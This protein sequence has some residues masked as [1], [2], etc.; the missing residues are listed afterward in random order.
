MKPEV[1]AFFS[2]VIVALIGFIGQFIM[3]KSQRKDK[4]EDQKNT[5]NLEILQTLE[6]IKENL[7][8][9]WEEVKITRH[10][11]EENS[12]IE[13]RIRILRFADEILHN[14][15]HTKD[16]FD[17]TMNDITRYEKYCREHP[18]FSNNITVNSVQI[19]E[20]NFKK[21]FDKNDFL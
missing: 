8:E 3:Y 18:D 10:D 13:C 4:I 5:D 21:R 9:I 14:I 2:A 15:A 1:I 17:Q 19:I 7:N 16:H 11:S 12:I 6:K 20:E